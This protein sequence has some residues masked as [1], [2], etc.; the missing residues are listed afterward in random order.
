MQEKCSVLQVEVIAPVRVIIYKYRIVDLSEI[1][2]GEILMKEKRNLYKKAITLCLMIIM[3]MLS[4]QNIVFADSKLSSS[5]DPLTTNPS[6]MY[7]EYEG[8]LESADITVESGDIAAELADVAVASAA[9]STRAGYS[10][11]WCRRRVTIHGTSSNP[12]YF[13]RGAE[14]TSITDTTWD[15][16][17]FEVAIFVDR[18]TYSSSTGYRYFA[19][20]ECGGGASAG[21][22][23]IYYI[24]F[25]AN[26]TLASTLHSY[27]SAES[28]HP[29][30]AY[31]DCGTSKTIENTSCF[32][33]C[34]SYIHYY[35]NGGSGAPDK[36]KVTSSSVKLSSVIPTRFKYRFDG[37][38]TSSTA[39]SGEL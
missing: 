15:K 27:G 13:Y 2:K 32:S 29:H 22:I 37:W 25:S 9:G 23:I 6:T 21:Q 36:Q 26:I 10:V 39:Q 16:Y 19:D 8:E 31:C 1:M 3:L 17:N 33:C 20:I 28:A 14:H 38:S 5:D 12:V 35:A 34:P 24:P 7:G 30:R 4:L 11:Y 18:Y